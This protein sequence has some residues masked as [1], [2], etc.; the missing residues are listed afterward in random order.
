MNNVFKEINSIAEQY[1]SSIGFLDALFGEEKED[2]IN[3]KPVVICCAGDLGKHML[4]TLRRHGISPVALCDNDPRKVG[5]SHLQTPILS[6]DDAFA[7]HPGAIF[8]IAAYKQRKEIFRQLTEMGIRSQSI[9]CTDEKS[10][11]IYLYIGTGTQSQLS[12]T[13]KA[14]TPLRFIDY[15]EQKQDRI[16][17]AHDILCDDKSRRLLITKLALLGSHGQFSLFSDYVRNFSE[18]YRDFGLMG[19]DGTPEDYYYFNNDIFKMADDEVYIDVGAFDGDTV[20]TFIDACK[21]NNKSYHEIIAFEPDPG[22]F[23]KLSQNY[24]GQEKIVL[25]KLG[26]WS[27][28]TQLKFFSTDGGAYEQGASISNAGDISIEVVSLDDFLQGKKITLL[29]MDP[30][31]NIIPDVLRGAQSTIQKHHPNL[32]IG[33]YHG[34]DSLFEIPLQVHRLSSKYRIALRQNTC[35]L[36]DTDL[37]ATTAAA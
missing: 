15:L 21:R 35:H 2:V 32:A 23:Q 18:P 13:Q 33:A 19:Y 30:P 37:L 14:C 24:A 10:D 27:E 3:G 36:S 11:L 22:C 29:K 16:A 31:G 6:F 34:P 20:E 26:L 9:K 7:A 17:A 8:V 12:L 5:S 25:S 1:T 4:T 28:S